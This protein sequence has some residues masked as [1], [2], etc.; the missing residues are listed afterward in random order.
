MAAYTVKS[1]NER[2][3]F[4]NFLSFS[5]SRAEKHRTRIYKPRLEQTRSLSETSKTTTDLC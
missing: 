5:T 1:P 3:L 2:E 4:Q